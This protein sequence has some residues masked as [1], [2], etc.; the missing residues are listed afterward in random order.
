MV[1]RKGRDIK[2]FNNSKAEYHKDKTLQDLFHGK[3]VN[4]NDDEIE[5]EEL[6]SRLKKLYW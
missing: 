1:W 6:I 3:I 4:I 2:K 5:A